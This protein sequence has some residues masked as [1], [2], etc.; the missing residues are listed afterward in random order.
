M[1]LPFDNPLATLYV[2]GGLGG[3]LFGET[4]FLVTESPSAIESSLA[5]KI[6]SKS[7]SL[8]Q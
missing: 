4:L 1:H 6:R 3:G 5:D 7:S 8:S 2:N